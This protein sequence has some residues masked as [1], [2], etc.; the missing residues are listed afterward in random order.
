MGNLLI[1]FVSFFLIGLFTF[2]GGYAMIPMIQETVM[3]RGWMESIDEIFSFI[4]IAEATPG[5]FAVNIATFIGFEQKGILGAAF[6]TFGVV[7]PS[8]VIILIIAIL[9]DK[10]LKTKVMKA[11]LKG[12]R[13]VVIGLILSVA[14]GILFKNIFK[15][16]LD[17]FNLKTNGFDLISFIIFVIILFLS[18]IKINKKKISPI[19]LILI[20]GFI[21]MILFSIM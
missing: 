8:F 5:P 13:P 7:L 16:E 20:S 6:A 14:I 10:L 12:I 18:K 19:V 9:G 15:A 1:L 17:I 21:G 4:G 3:E 2:G 11:A